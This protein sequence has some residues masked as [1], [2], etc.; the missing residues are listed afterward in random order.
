MVSCRNKHNK[1]SGLCDHVVA[2]GCKE[3]VFGN[4]EHFQGVTWQANL[5]YI[6]DD[7]E[8]ILNSETAYCCLSHCILFV[9]SVHSLFND[10]YYIVSNEG[11]IS[12]RWIGK[13]VEGSGC[14]LILRYYPSIRLE[15]LTKPTNISV[16]R[17]GLLAEIWTLDLPNTTTRPR[18][19]VFV[20]SCL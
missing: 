5:N 20:L 4:V 9:L 11:V 6:H 2:W 18:R 17:A 10:S 1:L 7:T 15:G 3:T 16:R 19:L 8:S 13:D 12:E 14:G